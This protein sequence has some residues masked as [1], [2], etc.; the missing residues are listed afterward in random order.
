MVAKD[1]ML[2]SSFVLYAQSA[3]A[4]CPV[5]SSIAFANDAKRP[6]GRTRPSSPIPP[7]T[8]TPFTTQTRKRGPRSKKALV[9]DMIV[10]PALLPT[11]RGRDSNRHVKGSEHRISR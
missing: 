4:R 7:E 1:E 9:I 6:G 10:S 3:H 2:N 11:S 5:S 8:K